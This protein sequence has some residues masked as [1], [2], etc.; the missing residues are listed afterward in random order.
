MNQAEF[1]KQVHQ[2]HA[3]EINERCMD[4]VYHKERAL[5]LRAKRRKTVA[6]RIEWAE[7]K[8]RYGITRNRGRQLHTTIDAHI[9][10]VIENITTREL[11]SVNITQSN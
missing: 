6:E 11:N 9:K 5:A 7:L 3:N 10:Q 2:N 4:F 1:I 8:A